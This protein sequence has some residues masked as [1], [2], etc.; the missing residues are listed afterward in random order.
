[1]ICCCEEMVVMCLLLNIVK[2]MEENLIVLWF[3]ELEMFECVV[4]WIDCILVFGGFD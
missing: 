1:M 4:E 2:V 3:K